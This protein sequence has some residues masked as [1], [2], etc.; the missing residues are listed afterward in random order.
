MKNK[1][2][3][4]RNI[5]I[6]GLITVTAVM[7]FAACSR[8][9]AKYPPRMKG[10][11]V[12]TE[13][14][15]Q[16]AGP[17][18][19][20]GGW[21]AAEDRTVTSDLEKVFRKAT[22]GLTGVDYEPVEYLGSQVVAGLNHCFLAKATAVYPGAVPHYSLVYIYERFDGTCEITGIEDTDISASR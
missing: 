9:A 7:G 11:D 20:A 16:Y 18:Q 8:V 3:I 5:A 14:A 15:E 19:L 12:T 17:V 2:M 1:N 22:D 6:T 10:E 4:I 21:T 13:P